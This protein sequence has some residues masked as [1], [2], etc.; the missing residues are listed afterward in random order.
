M[1]HYAQ[2]IQTESKFLPPTSLPTETR[3]RLRAHSRALFGNLDRLEVAAAI[4]A[5]DGMVNATDLQWQ[6]RIANNRV[7]TQLVVLAELGLLQHVEMETRKRHY[8]RIESAFWPTC[9]DLYGQWSQ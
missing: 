1:L 7:R 3:E 9:L 5:S 6:L 2:I 8:L 4:A